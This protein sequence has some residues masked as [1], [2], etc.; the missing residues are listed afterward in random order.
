VD[1][2]GF[3]VRGIP[4]RYDPATCTPAP[5]VR[6]RLDASGMPGVDGEL[7]SFTDVTPGC[8]VTFQ[9]VARNDGF[10]ARTCADQLFNMR[11]IVVG[12]D[13]VEADSRVVVARVPGDRSLCP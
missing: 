13:V 8:L 9:I 4:V 10:V 11:V 1:E 6:D 3:F 12:D 5:N 2:T 7:D